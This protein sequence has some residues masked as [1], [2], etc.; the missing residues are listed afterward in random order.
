[1]DIHKFLVNLLLEF[2][3][4]VSADDDKNVRQELTLFS[5]FQPA[6]F[7]AQSWHA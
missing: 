7:R 6:D 2:S 5:S 1:M 3:K 4:N